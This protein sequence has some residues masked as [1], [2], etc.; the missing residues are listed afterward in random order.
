[1][2]A[3]CASGAHCTGGRWAAP[4][5]RMPPGW[6]EAEGVAATM[7]V[8]EDLCLVI[9]ARLGAAAA[10]ML[11]QVSLARCTALAP[12]APQPLPPLLVAPRALLPCSA[13]FVMLGVR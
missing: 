13:L 10:H 1:M 5:A 9:M 7:A 11:I 4:L 6:G 2:P 12:R 8:R 3:Q